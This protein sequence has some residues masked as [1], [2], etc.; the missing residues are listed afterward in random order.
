V[1]CN[2]AVDIYRFTVDRDIVLK[3]GM[4]VSSCC[5]GVWFKLGAMVLVSVGGSIVAA[6]L[7]ELLKDVKGCGKVYMCDRLYPETVI[8]FVFVWFVGV[9]LAVIHNGPENSKIS[10]LELLDDSALPTCHLVYLTNVSLCI[11]MFCVV[12]WLVWDVVKACFVLPRNLRGRIERFFTAWL[13][14]CAYLSNYVMLTLFVYSRY[15]FAMKLVYKSVCYDQSID[16]FFGNAVVHTIPFCVL[17]V[18]AY[19]RIYHRSCS[20]DEDS[21]GAL[22]SVGLLFSWVALMCVLSIYAYVSPK[23]HFDA[24]KIDDDYRDRT[25]LFAC[26]E[27]VH[28]AFLI[29]CVWVIIPFMLASLFR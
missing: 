24:Y 23:Y 3:A 19:L 4:G 16:V 25:F 2:A 12:C 8:G 28:I 11:E 15:S 27:T 13:V 17:S 21:T 26:N 20:D 6:W 18:V 14:L 9:C 10:T 1:I 22:T 5:V 7:S 29:L